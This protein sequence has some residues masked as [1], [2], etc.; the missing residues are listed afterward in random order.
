MQLTCSINTI[1]VPL[2]KPDE[3]P[4]CEGTKTERTLTGTIE[5]LNSPCLLKIKVDTNALT[6]NNPITIFTKVSP[7][8]F[9]FIPNIG[10][11][12]ITIM[13]HNRSVAHYPSVSTLETFT[14]LQ[15]RGAINTF[16]DTI[17]KI[18]FN[19]FLTSCKSFFYSF[20]TMTQYIIAGALTATLSSL[21]NGSTKINT[22]GVGI[23]QIASPFVTA[24][25]KI[26]C[27][28]DTETLGI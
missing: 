3:Y 19:S 24:D 22:L 23:L 1:D 15:K 26:G 28:I 21:M 13:N 16:K 9:D 14:S 8:V 5:A 7:F 12:T 4:Y 18:T 20:F 25:T 6:V 27:S 2:L 17:N 10:N 11:N